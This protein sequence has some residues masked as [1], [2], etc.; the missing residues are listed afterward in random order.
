LLG[1]LIAAGMPDALIRDQLLTLIIAG[2]DTST[3]LLSWT[4]YLLSNHP[5]VQ[6]R[7][8]AELD[9][10]LGSA[11]PSLAQL[12]QL[13]YLE[14]VINE[15]LRLYPPIHLGSRIA[16]EDLEFQ[17]HH[18]PTGQRVLYSIYLTQRD[19]RYWDKPA[20]FCP[21]RFA[22][23]LSRQHL[24]YTFQPFGGGSRNCIGMAFA[25]V[26]VKVVLARILQHFDLR[27]TGHS[28]RLRMGATL[29]P[30][31]GVMVIAQR[32]N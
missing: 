8:Q 21:E 2:H 16:A 15:T 31:P 1:L 28:V 23:A 13:S 32:R 7:V 22:P 29:E 14:Q 6:A 10:V 20:E 5:E 3:A 26:E 17:G 9:S 4:L 27:F 25:Q 19:P 12:G 11:P 18:I 30:A 24:P